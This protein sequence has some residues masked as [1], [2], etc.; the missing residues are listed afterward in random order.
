[1]TADLRKPSSA[2][3]G[4]FTPGQLRFLMN[5]VIVMGV[6]LIFGFAVLMGGIVYQASRLDKSS[7]AATG[8]QGEA[9]A[10]FELSVPAGMSVTHMAL[11]GN[12]LAVHLSGP[13]GAEIRVIDLR[14][15]EIISRIG[16][17]SK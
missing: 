9:I 8:T 16:V 17:K 4:N 3:T 14:K 15:N 10:P 1:M 5:A 13:N 7:L 6:V 12:R 11:D 2:R